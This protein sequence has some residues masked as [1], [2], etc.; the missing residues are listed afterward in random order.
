ML[1]FLASVLM[2]NFVDRL[3]LGLVLQDIKVDLVLDDTQLG[4]LTGIAFALFYSLMGIPIARWADRGNRVTIISITTVLWSIA[5]A[6]CGTATTFGQ[7]LLIRILVAVGEAGCVPAA[8][9]LIADYFDRAERPRA[10]ARYMSGGAFSGVIGYF[11][12]G[13]LNERFGWRATFVLVGLPGVLLAI[14]ARFILI[15]PRRQL[16]LTP[17]V[18]PPRAIATG[19]AD[20]PS[21]IEVGTVLWR[22]TTFRHLL[23]CVS[24]TFF[25]GFGL[26]LWQPSFFIRIYGMS[27]A[28]LGLWLTLVG[29][30]GNL[31]GTYGG[32]EWAFRWA[33]GDERRQLRMMAM[34][35]SIFAFISAVTYLVPNKYAA[36]ALMGLGAMGINAGTGPLFGTIQA[37][38]PERMRAVAVAMIYL[39]ANLIGMGLGPLAAGALSDLLRAT[40]GAQSLRYALVAFS[41]GYLWCA[42]HLL[43]ASRSVTHD[44]AGERSTH[45]PTELKPT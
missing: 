43:R 32:G 12:A 42:W 30:V 28:E 37:L 5:V 3:V 19:A 15:E 25:F 6:L 13:W 31:L 34:L 38:V 22:I 17:A 45:Q 26:Q 14:A 9:S 1:A 39:F 40:V 18:E 8:H 36:L 4:F 7:L 27:T 23:L 33:A 29:G 10:L 21:L 35:Y 11:L 2:F 20:Q 16:P 44:L 41:P 24:I